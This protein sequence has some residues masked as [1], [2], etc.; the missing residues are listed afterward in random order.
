MD[1][2]S[3]DCT[4]TNTSSG[5]TVTINPSVDLPDAGGKAIRVTIAEGV[6]LD[7]V[8]NSY[9]GLANADYTFSV[10]DSSAVD[11]DPSGY[12]PAQ[13]ATAAKTTGVTLT[14]LED[15][16]AGVGSIV[17]TSSGGNM[18]D[19]VVVV[20]VTNTTQ[21]YFAGNVM[22]VVPGQDFLD[23][24]NK[25]I[26]VTIASGVIK[27]TSENVFP[28]FTG[29]DYQ[30]IVADSTPPTIT[31]LAPT[32]Q[33]SGLLKTIDIVLTF[34]EYVKAGSG[35]IILTPS[36]GTGSNAATTIDVTSGQVV[37][38]DNTATISPAANLLDTGGKSYDVTMAS[39]VITDVAASNPFAGLSSGQYTFDI[40]DS[41]QASIIGY[42]PNQ[43]K[44]KPEPEPEPKPKP[45]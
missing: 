7:D 15:V 21:V 8:G 6:I 34:S 10:E 19:H 36:G 1:I 45:S 43:G 41:T 24:G 40:V 18:N 39:G 13:G 35:N 30:F 37:F 27:D 17:F 11:I 20:D 3:S 32:H 33:A 26:T 44:P 31:Q 38:N 16:D 14:F 22:I 2:T 28:G 12:Q 29:N 23:T 42:S 9:P 5:T 4:F 25:T